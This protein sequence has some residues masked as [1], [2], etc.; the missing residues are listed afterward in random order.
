MWPWAKKVNAVTAA[1]WTY[2]CEHMVI[3]R[4]DS[5]E[6]INTSIGPHLDEDRWFKRGVG[7]GKHPKR[8]QL[9]S[10]LELKNIQRDM[11]KQWKLTTV[12]YIPSVNICNTP[13]GSVNFF[14]GFL[15]IYITVSS[16]Y[17]RRMLT[18]L[19]QLLFRSSVMS[20]LFLWL[21]VFISVSVSLLV[22]RQSQSVVSAS[23]SKYKMQQ[24]S[25]KIF[26]QLFRL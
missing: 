5:G 9:P 22:Y 10:T 18:T 16:A 17:V 26:V 21:T 24:C 14:T 4:G 11:P 20:A 1:L 19:H 3:T 2:C 25:S 7:E 8:V 23:S 6:G 12:P 13:L 15:C